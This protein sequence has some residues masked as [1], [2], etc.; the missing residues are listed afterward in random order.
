MNYKE[1]KNNFKSLCKYNKLSYKRG[2]RAKFVISRKY[3][4]FFSGIRNSTEYE[5]FQPSLASLTEWFNHWRN[6]LNQMSIISKD[7]TDSCERILECV[8]LDNDLMN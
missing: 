3:L 4:N 1:C 2:K 5:T 7:S 6:L 8:T